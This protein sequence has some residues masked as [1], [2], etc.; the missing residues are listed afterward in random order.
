MSEKIKSKIK[1]IED[2]N[3]DF[4]KKFD[5]YDELA[6]KRLL[7]A[8]H[9]IE[10]EVVN[11][12]AKY[13]NDEKMNEGKKYRIKQA[14]KIRESLRK[15]FEEY[16]DE[17]AAIT[18]SYKESAK[19][20]IGMLRGI[21]I[22]PEFSESDKDI[23]NA[24]QQVAYNEFENL[25][26]TFQNRIGTI[27][28]QSVLTDQ[29]YRVTVANVRNALTGIESRTGKPMTQYAEQIA[30]DEYMKFN[31]AFETQK[32][33]ELGIK[34]YMYVGSLIKDSRPFCVARAGKIFTSEEVES[35]NKL[36]WAGKNP[37]LPVQIACGGY[38]CRHHLQPLTDEMA[39]YL[40][41][42]EGEK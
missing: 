23:I 35:W 38:N 17:S 39:E 42:Q 27:L 9:T 25:G 36:D 12:T 6:K 5:R 11:W 1:A 8:I 15:I 37:N 14:L 22:P 21:G 26:L 2:W 29:P 10:D 7:K 31:R 24:L 13:F 40:K 32:T 19:N 18:D 34:Y 30:H 28:Y 33:K 41:Q 4:Q 3:I 16:Y 20:I